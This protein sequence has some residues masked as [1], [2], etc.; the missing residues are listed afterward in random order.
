MVAKIESGK[1]MRGILHYNEDKVLAG[2]AQLI[3]ASGF[4]GDIDKMSLVQ[5]LNR[6]KHL[7]DLNAKVKTNALHISLNFDA[8]DKPDNARLQKIATE[9]MERI[10]FGDQPFLVY[11]HE[12]AHHPHVH[13]AT[14]NIRRDGQR[15]DIH[16]IGYRLSEPA[17]K[18]LENKYGLVKAEGRQMQQDQSVD[19]AKY[20]EK[21]TR[22]VISNIVTRVAR[23]YAFTSFAEYKAV[24]QGFGILADRGSEDTRMFEKRGLQYAILDDQ[25]K[26][27][28]IPVKAS[29]IYSKPTLNNIEKKFTPNREKRK[30]HKDA[31]IKTLDL[32]LNRTNK[33]SA[34][35]LEMELVKRGIRPV[36]RTSENGRLYGITYI[37]Q[38]NKTV[39]NGSDLGK[40]Y[41][42]KAIEEKLRQSPHLLNTSVKQATRK[43]TGQLPSQNTSPQAPTYFK[44]PEPTNFLEMVLARTDP[45]QSTGVPKTRRKRKK[46]EQVQQDNQLTL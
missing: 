38:R 36:F 17:R 34:G 23:E 46:G 15:I 20:G 8:S 31:L 35:P 14:T 10:G 41:S 19:V 24:L 32:V 29:S 9:Y 11:R 25:G 45:E 27:V 44:A 43:G 2:T 13:I 16:G 40:A 22:Q 4:A 12:D 6:F 30:K 42:A 18:E 37:D 39:F 5:K 33:A 3:L 26:A 21:P 1:G 28:G 7:T